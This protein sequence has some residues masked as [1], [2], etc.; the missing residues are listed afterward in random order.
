MK[1]IFLDIDGVMN[2]RVFFEAR[3]KSRRERIRR[4]LN[5]IK[6]RIRRLFRSKENKYKLVN[7]TRDLS[8]EYQFSRLKAQTCPKKW[9]WLSEWCNEHDV[10]ICISSVWK[11]HFGNK[12]TVMP[13]RWSRALV[14]LGFNANC[15]V[16]ITGDRRTLRGT[17]IQEWLDS[18]T[19]VT[20]YAILDDDS[21]MLEHQ[22]NH[23]F[24][25]DGWFGMSPNH[26]YR[27]NR[28]FNKESNYKNITKSL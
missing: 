28:H 22:F 23:F 5:R 6:S 19:E 18:H 3:Y 17:E 27:I 15:F 11:R 13:Q 14:D 26:L 16:G 7:R 12:D 24:H 21:D 2:S 8:Y 20:G 10:K 9:E 25:C 4:T 1:V